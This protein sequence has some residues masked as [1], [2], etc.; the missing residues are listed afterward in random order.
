MIRGTDAKGAPKRVAIYC[1][2]S[3]DRQASKEDSSLDTQK[4]RLLEYIKA[5]NGMGHAWELAQEFIEGEDENGKR[6]GRSA[7]N[8]DRP[9]FQ[10]LMEMVRGGRMDVVLF[11]KIDRISRSVVDFLRLIEEFERHGVSL[12]SLK[13]DI[14]TESA[15][16]RVMTT[17]MIALAQFER[18]QTS[19]RTREKMAWRA[20]KG[21][22]IGP[23]PVGY[24]MKDKR[25][26]VH[27]EELEHVRFLERAYLDT[28]SL[29][30]VAKMAYGKGIRSRRG[31]VLSKAAIGRILQSPVYTGKIGHKGQAYAGQHEAT[32]DEKTHRQIQ[33]HL[34]RN[35]HHKGNGTC[36][37]R[38]YDYLLQGLVVCGFCKGRMTPKW[39]TGRNGQYHYYV[40]SK[41]DKTTGLACMR[42]LLPAPEADAHVLEYVKRL[43]LREDL[44]RE[45]CEQQD[46]NF[47]RDLDRKRAERDQ[48]QERIS[49]NRRQATNLAK[50]IAKMATEAS[51]AM[52]QTAR[53]LERERKALE[54]SLETLRKEIEGL[55]EASVQVERTG[56]TLRYLSD[57]LGQG[58]LTAGHLRDLLPKFINYIV[59]T[60][61]QDEEAKARN[62]RL[63][64]ALFERPFRAG[65]GRRLQEIVEEVAQGARAAQPAPEGDGPGHSGAGVASPAPFR[66]T[67]IIWRPIPSPDATISTTRIAASASGLLAGHVPPPISN[68]GTTD[69]TPESIPAAPVPEADEP[70]AFLIVTE[71]YFVV[72]QRGRQVILSGREPAG[73]RRAGRNP[74]RDW[75]RHLGRMRAQRPAAISV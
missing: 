20:G 75:R 13:E 40:C 19:E 4:D 46:E 58:G 28:R 42:N 49:E 36:S 18:E 64:I 43:A 60:A 33:Q 23:P 48:V 29:D 74:G 66:K 8:L 38:E 22:P 72:H 63:E 56:R 14:N 61:A 12:V 41:G 16:G 53:D 52:L 54:T 51:D 39:S 25:Y 71:E 44:I 31:G 45:L 34:L 26:V 9:A 62:G 10:R 5:K 32:R 3:T 70:P 57:I 27:P 7:K 69:C 24:R 17:I 55:Q 73:W 68:P 11:T 6:R 50:S 47:A 21:L 59:W 37:A 2:V 1:R 67:S 15:A 65:H 30:Q 35:W